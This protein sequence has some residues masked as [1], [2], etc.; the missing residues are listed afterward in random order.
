MKELKP[1]PLCGSKAII[2]R[3]MQPKEEY[4]IQCTSCSLR[5]GRYAGL[6][7]KTA[8]KAW[9]K[10]ATEIVVNQHGD[11]CVNISNCGT[12]NLEL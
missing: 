1:C 8:I 3:F 2:D 12:L 7:E 11:N 6:S 4:R 5:F 9:N 10:R